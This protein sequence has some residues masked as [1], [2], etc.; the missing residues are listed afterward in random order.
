M[1]YSKCWKKDCE[2]GIWYPGKLSIK[3]KEEIKVS[4]GKYKMREFLANRPDLWENK[5]TLRWNKR[6]IHSN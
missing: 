5:G 2:P 1:T 6:V 3:N 4:L